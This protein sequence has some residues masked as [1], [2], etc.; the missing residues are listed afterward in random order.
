MSTS[1]LKN[2]IKEKKVKIGSEVTIKAIR[3]GNAKEVFISSNCPNELKKRLEKYCEISKCK[4]NLLKENSKELG[5]ICK[6]PFSINICYS[7][8]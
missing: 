4:I 2:L 8:K 5:D 6:K 7:I 1:D 3:D